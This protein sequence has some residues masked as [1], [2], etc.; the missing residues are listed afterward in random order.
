MTLPA[1]EDAARFATFTGCRRVWAISA[2]HAEIARLEGVHD[3]IQHRL[4]PRDALVYLGNMLGR[5]PAI[6]ET[7]AELLTFRRD[8]IGRERTFAADLAFLR[9]SQE[10]MWQRLLE[11]QFAPEPAAVL[12]WMLD[13]GLA[14]VVAAYG[15][16]GA[17]G[18]AACREGPLA[19]TRWTSAIRAAINAA[20]GHASLM[21]ALRRAAFTSG[22][23]LLFVHAGIDPSRPLTAQNDSFWWGGSGFLDLKESYAGFRKV[24]RGFDRHH[25]GLQVTPYAVSMDRGCGFDG[26]LACACFGLDGTLIESFE[27]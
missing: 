25:G 3:A 21:T 18:L 4:Q 12:E 24:V 23:E 11:L 19:I 20:P 13:H 15:T 14:P 16:D 17:R 26:T 9:G 10:E 5:G 27:A 1:P 8:F 7:I 22:G 2:I 6:R